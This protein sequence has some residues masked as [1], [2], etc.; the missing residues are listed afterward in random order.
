MEEQFT[1]IT[2]FPA[3]STST[4]ISSALQKDDDGK[5]KNECTNITSEDDHENININRESGKNSELIR[6]RKRKHTSAT[7]EEREYYDKLNECVPTLKAM[8]Q[9]PNRVEILNHTCD[10]IRALREMLTDLK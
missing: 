5:T 1:V 9:R 2:T 7:T 3:S 8:E 10:Y 6:I 4:I